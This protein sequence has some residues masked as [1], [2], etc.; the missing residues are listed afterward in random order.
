MTKPSEG[1]AEVVGFVAFSPMACFRSLSLQCLLLRVA[2]AAA[3]AAGARTS[4]APQR[5]SLEFGSS[6][7]KSSSHCSSSSSS[8]GS[9]GGGGG[10]VLGSALGCLGV[11]GLA[12]G[13][14]RMTM[15]VA[16]AVPASAAEEE[17]NVGAALPDLLTE[18]MVDMKCEGCVTTVRNKIE[19]LEGVK[20]VEVDLANQVVRILG[21][22]TVKNLTTAIEQSGRHVRLIGQGVPS[23][24][25]VSAAVAEFKGPQIHGVVRFAQVSMEMSRIEASFSGLT[26]GPHGWSINMYGDL[27]QG[28]ASTGGI[29][30]PDSAHSAASTTE[31]MGELGILEVGSDGAAEY[32]G[33]KMGLQVYDLIG[34][35]VVIYESE[36][37]SKE[38]ITA[39]VIARS[40]GVGQNYKKLC[41]CDGT[42]IWESTNS[43]FVKL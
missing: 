32:T 31:I 25:S 40:A 10:G 24:F 6:W 39:A 37:K 19:P 16:D 20:A 3:A 26:P 23:E 14:E 11:G 36:D 43:D 8:R 41:S 7:C 34:R 9:A 22:A 12:L 42:V 1:E 17:K 35:A 38:A 21:S 27:T 13:S 2:S 30:R 29:Y 28:A 15:A 18:F 33:K 5:L 4:F